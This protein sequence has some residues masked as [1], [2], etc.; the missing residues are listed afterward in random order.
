MAVFGAC[1]RVVEKAALP[2]LLFAYFAS[3]L[4]VGSACAYTASI[5]SDIDFLMLTLGFALG[6]GGL[7][8][9][10]QSA[11]FIKK[12]ALDFPRYLL[13]KLTQGIICALLS[14]FLFKGWC[15]IF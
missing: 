14:L 1:V 2:E 5:I 8:A 3:L 6:F 12:A 4:E 9:H 13:M 10:L 15:I 11:V 7:C